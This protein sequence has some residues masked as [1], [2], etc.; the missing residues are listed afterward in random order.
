MSKL[1][2]LH[3]PKTA[4]STF[5]RILRAQFKGKKYF[6]FKGK[7]IAD[8]ERYSALPE[9]ERKS[10]ELFVG[11]APL[12]SGVKEADEIPIITILRDPLSRIKSFC[13]HASEGKSAYLLDEFPP[14][15]FSLDEFLYSGNSELSNLQSRML[16]NYEIDG[17]NLS[18][19]TLTED[20]LKVQALN[21][22]FNK[23]ACFGVQEY[24][25]ESL[26]LFADRLKWRTPYYEYR[27]RKN[28]SR[29]LTFEQRHID[30]II[31]LNSVD[32]EVYTAARDKFEK[33]MTSDH[34]YK[35]KFEK[36]KRNQKLVL[37]LMG[38]YGGAGRYL[39]GKY[40]AIKDK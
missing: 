7:N 8:I 18:G 31:E 11:H 36:F 27:N 32:I 34:R 1:R 19:S 4:G 14:E 25:D 17:S 16:V 9:S 35:K 5:W 12:Y 30:R 38:L 39:K 24:F 13:Q 20:K 6:L 28:T 21:N 26:V 23:V 33:L 2:F 3:I 15:T 37:P 29:L 10:I 22:L 40:R